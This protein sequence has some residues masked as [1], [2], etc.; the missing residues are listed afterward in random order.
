MFALMTV[1]EQYRIFL[2]E[3][4][5]IYNRSEAAAISSTVFESIAGITRAGI[6]K[7]PTQVLDKKILQRLDHCLLQLKIHKP[8]Q[9][10][11]GE[12]W[13]CKMKLKVSPAVLIPRP[14]TEELA[15]AVISYL[16]DKPVASVLDIGT[17]S[18]C[19]AIAIKKNL[20]DTS[21]TAIDISVDAL[22]IAKENASHQQTSINFLR[23]DFLHER[24]WQSLPL[25]DV[26]VSNPPYIPQHEKKTLDKNVIEFEPHLALFVENNQPLI[27]YEKMAVFGKT[28]LKESGKIFMETHEHFAKETAE[29]FNDDHYSSVIQNDLYEKQRMVIATRRFP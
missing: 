17:G 27:F 3:L 8:V 14:E 29:L 10:V 20:P 6:I 25:F 23:S 11:T 1:N 4:E 7:Y 13:F 26:I 16:K 12:T 5:H 2:A 19:I 24:T 22:N 9:Y 15:G 28:H 18:G 21:V